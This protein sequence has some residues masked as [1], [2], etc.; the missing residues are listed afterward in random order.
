MCCMVLEYGMYS[1]CVSIVDIYDLYRPYAQ[2]Q[3]IGESL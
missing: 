1:M 2:R 3:N